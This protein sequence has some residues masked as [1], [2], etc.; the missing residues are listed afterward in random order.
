MN[1][2]WLFSFFFFLVIYTRLKKAKPIKKIIYIFQIVVL[3]DA[4][5]SMNELQ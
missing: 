2:G 3:V 1:Q 5:L 4:S